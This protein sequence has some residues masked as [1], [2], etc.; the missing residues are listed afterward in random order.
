MCCDICPYFDECEDL[1]ELQEDCCPEC[2]DYH[3]C[4]ERDAEQS[5]EEEES[6]S[7]VPAE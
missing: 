3:D 7:G 1:D 5:E 6:D 2:P 4:Q